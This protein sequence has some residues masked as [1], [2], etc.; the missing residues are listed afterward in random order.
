MQQNQNKK[1]KTSFT[2][3]KI[4]IGALSVTGTV[5]I[6]GLIAEKPVDP[7]L[8]LKDNSNF[9]HQDS[10]SMIVNLQPLPTLVPIRSIAGN[11]SS[12]EQT[13]SQLGQPLRQVG[14]PTLAPIP[15]NNNPVFERLAITRPSSVSSSGAASSGSSR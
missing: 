4:L 7:I 8:P 14:Q 15:V 13:S 11:Q 5:G 12:I 6:W 1:R 10:N 9:A 2:S 3:W